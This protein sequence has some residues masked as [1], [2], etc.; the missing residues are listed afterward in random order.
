[1]DLNLFLKHKKIQEL[2]IKQIVNEMML[3]QFLKEEENYKIL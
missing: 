3:N 2:L 1:M